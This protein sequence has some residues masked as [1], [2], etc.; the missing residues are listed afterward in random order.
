MA[1]SL[2]LDAEAL[3]LSGGEDYELIFTVRRS[4]PVAAVIA[5][6]L[7]CRVTEIGTVQAGRGAR[8]FRD[9][10][11]TSAPERGFEHFKTP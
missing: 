7:G 11:R 9:G 8:Y 10:V 4:A 2:G 5:S 3:A 1:E 6:A